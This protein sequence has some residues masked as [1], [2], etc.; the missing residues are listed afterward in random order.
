VVL[1][2][3]LDLIAL[4]ADSSFGSGIYIHAAF[5]SISFRGVSNDLVLPIR[6]IPIFKGRSGD[7]G[8]K[9]VRGEPNDTSSELGRWRIISSIMKRRH[10]V[11]GDQPL[12]SCTTQ[13]CFGGGNAIVFPK[14]A[15]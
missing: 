7:Y 8:P 6:D 3:K 9:S 11:F 4:L 13:I 15:S 14:S 12:D 1:F 10:P 2:P 5:S